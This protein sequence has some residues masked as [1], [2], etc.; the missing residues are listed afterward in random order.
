MKRVRWF[1]ASWPES[2][3]HIISA[4]RLN[5][6]TQANQSGFLLDRV[7]ENSVEGRY[8]ERKDIHETIIDPFGKE[9]AIQRLVFDQIEFAIFDAFPAI[10]L[11]DAP[12]IVQSFICRLL[13]ICSF[14]LSIASR[15]VDLLR[16]IEELQQSLDSLLVIESIQ[17]S[18]YEFEAGV[19]GKILL[20]GEHDVRPVLAKFTNN[21]HVVL[22]N[23]RI[24]VMSF[25]KPVS[26]S[27][28]ANG[29]A[30]FPEVHADYLLPLL[31]QSLFRL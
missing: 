3:Q 15:Q 9:I 24:S 10:E 29:S 20:S 23:A 12:R 2:L 5:L 18:G 14:N 22:A 28:S 1:Q 19:V 21:K 13:E 26:I 17:I 27:L 31:R 7:R 11:Y 6:F 30:R 4:F 8:I 16:W 25:G